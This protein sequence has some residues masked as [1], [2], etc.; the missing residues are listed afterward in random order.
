MKIKYEIPIRSRK[1]KV[2]MHRRSKT[3][4]VDGKILKKSV[5]TYNNNFGSRIFGV[6]ILYMKKL[7]KGA[8]R[9]G[10]IKSRKYQRIVQL[11]KNAKGIRF[12]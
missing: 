8:G 9:D 4:K 6:R 2:T 3:V 12:E 10:R 5:G 7:K 11:P 1:N